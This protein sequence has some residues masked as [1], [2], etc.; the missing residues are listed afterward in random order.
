MDYK[1]KKVLVVGMSSS[2]ISASYLLERLGAKVFYYDDNIN[3]NITQFTN[4]TREFSEEFLK[5]IDQIIVSPSIS[6]KHTV[7]EL[8]KK[9]N[10]KV[11][12]ELEFGTQFLDCQKIVVTGTNGKTTVVN[13]L[14]K[15]L[16]GANK[17]AKAMGN[18]GYPVSQVILDNTDLD[19]AIIE[20]SSFQLEHIE[21]FHA[22]IAVVLN[23]APD[24][25]DRY[26]SYGKYIEAKKNLIK[27]QK[28]NDYLFVNSEDKVCRQFAKESK[29]QSIFIS[30]KNRNTTVYLKDNYYMLKD[31]SLCHVKECRLRGEHNKFNLLIALNIGYML[32]ATKEHL[33]NLI[34]DYSLLPNRIE[35]VTTINGKSYYNDSKGTNMHATKYAIKSI[36]GDIGLIMGGSD[37]NEDFC[38]FF[39]DIDEKVK[40]IVVCGNNANSI[41]NSALKMGYTSISVANNLQKAIQLLSQSSAISSILFSPSSASFDRYK[42]YAERGERF[43]RL[44]YA[45]K[46]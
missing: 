46:D 41:F 14:E 6:I 26:D 2:G 24:H 11:I 5:T 15:L 31:I 20:V 1:N 34:R 16:L 25:L 38:D 9:L 3:L 13:M 36:D 17:K 32:G 8:A 22:D 18:I 29:A 42:N 12:S 23:I 10:I 7:I 37:K 45:I 44:V 40:L 39:E 21:T 19:Y 4:V 30:T 43:R 27:C 28:N 35:Y 33:V